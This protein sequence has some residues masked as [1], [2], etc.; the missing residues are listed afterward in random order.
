MCGR[1]TLTATQ[2]TLAEAFPGFGLPEQYTQRYNIAPSQAVAV[3]PNDGKKQVT[4]FRW[5]LIPGWAKDAKIGNKMINARSETLAEKP[6]FRTAYK[7]R[8]CLILADGFY[9]WQTLPGQKRKIPHFIHMKSRQPF[10]FAGLWEVWQPS[11]GDPV[12]SC[13]IITTDA[14]PL[15]DR[16]HPRM[17]VI[18]PPESYDRWLIPEPQ[19]HAQLGEL[20][21]AYPAE[22]MAHYPVSMVVNSPANDRPEC[23]ARTPG[24]EMLF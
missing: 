11:E 12:H 24:Q 9:E 6:A 2:Q 21:A 13:T 14:N 22:Q 16:L 8:R 17:P 15:L 7:Q 1:F 4:F 20:L 19:T 10:A 18:L 5:G 23:I 3:V